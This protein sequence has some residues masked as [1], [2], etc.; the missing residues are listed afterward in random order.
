MDDIRPR[1]GLHTLPCTRELPVADHL[2]IANYDEALNG[3]LHAV[4]SRQSAALIAPAGTGKS[5]VLRALMNRLPESLYR[6]SYVKVTGL[7]KRDMCREI[8]AAVGAEPAGSYPWLVRRLQERFEAAN[9]DG[10]RPVLLIDEAHDLRPEVLGMLR[11]LTNFDL[12]SRLVLSVVLAGQLPL[13]KLLKRPELDTVARR[14]V[15]YARLRTLT[16]DETKQYLRHRLT[17]AGASSV[18]FDDRALDAIYDIGAGNLRATDRLVLRSL[19]LAA[20]ADEDVVGTEHIAGARATLW[21]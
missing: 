12:D 9:T 11:I 4:E 16:R 5:N 1:F 13:A 19:E 20:K 10:I 8:A 17:V 6:V 3:L 15:H 7:S 14:L 21:P 2:A 18:P